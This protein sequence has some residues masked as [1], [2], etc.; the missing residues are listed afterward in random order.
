MTKSKSISSKK[1]NELT[2]NDTE[3]NTI[4]AT[5]YD[6]GIPHIVIKDTLKISLMSF[7]KYLDQNPNFKEEFLKAQEVGIKTLVEK[8]L[9]IFQSDTTEMSNEEL[10]FLREKQNYIKWLAPRISSLFTEKQKID[11]KSDSVVKISWED[12]QSDLIDVS[13]DITDIPPDNKD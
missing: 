4:L 3:Q 6:G 9:A 13:G 7:Y 2:L 1:K 8:M 5:I 10:L 12:N 11:V